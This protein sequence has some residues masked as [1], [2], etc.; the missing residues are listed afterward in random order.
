MRFD[1]GGGGGGGV[2]SAEVK[3]FTCASRCNE[4]V[5]HEGVD[6]AATPKPIVVDITKKR[7]MIFSSI[8]I[9]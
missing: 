2:S 8:L 3:V 6:N 9:E 1:G 7:R 5:A 4:S